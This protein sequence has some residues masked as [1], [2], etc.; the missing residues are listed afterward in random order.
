MSDVEDFTKPTIDQKDAY[1]KIIDECCCNAISDVLAACQEEGFE[2]EPSKV[3]DSVIR[4]AVNEMLTECGF[5]PIL[6]AGILAEM[7]QAIS[8]NTAKALIEMS[9]RM[10]AAEQKCD[11]HTC[12]R[13]REMN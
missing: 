8:L 7:I 9:E 13:K 4:W 5:A 2:V 11:C 12:K 3:V 1:R 10:K 6:V